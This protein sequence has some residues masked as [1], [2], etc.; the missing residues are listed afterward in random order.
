MG[1]DAVLA[2]ETPA[3]PTEKL[4]ENVLLWLPGGSSLNI[5]TVLVLK[6]MQLCLKSK[7][8]CVLY[9]N[10]PGKRLNTK[11]SGAPHL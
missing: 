7:E 8:V 6:T 5:S 2:T 9:A 10:V 4:T 3:T 11:L 1:T